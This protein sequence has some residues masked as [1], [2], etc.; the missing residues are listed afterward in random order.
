MKLVSKDECCSLRLA[1]FVLF[2][3]FRDATEVKSLLDPEIVM[4]GVKQQGA[5]L[6]E[7]DGSTMKMGSMSE[8]YL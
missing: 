1:P 7:V 6:S 8:S 2:V 3:D 5:V 4:P